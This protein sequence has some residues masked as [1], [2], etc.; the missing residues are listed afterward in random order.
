[1]NNNNSSNAAAAVG[2]NYSNYDNSYVCLSS[3]YNMSSRVVSEFTTLAKG[4]WL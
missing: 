1:M 4:E 2:Y 3:V